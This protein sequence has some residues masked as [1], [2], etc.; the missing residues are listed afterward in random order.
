MHFRWP[1][2]APETKPGR[3][4]PAANTAFSKRCSRRPPAPSS[5]RQH[6]DI[7]TPTQVRAHPGR[8]TDCNTPYLNYSWLMSTAWLCAFTP[9]S[10]ISFRSAGEAR[11]AERSSAQAKLL[12]L[13]FSLGE[14]DFIKWTS[15]HTI[16]AT[17]NP[18]RFSTRK[19]SRCWQGNT[20]GC[21]RLKPELEVEN[22]FLSPLHIFF[23]LFSWSRA[24]VCRGGKKRSV[25]IFFAGLISLYGILPFIQLF[26]RSY[27]Y[28]WQAK[29]YKLCPKL[30]F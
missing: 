8:P 18:V 3:K 22:Y 24:A 6:P 14:Y 4:E 15:L 20:E 1:T 7:C 29:I 11:G 12:M 17:G 27:S 28:V 21:T 25:G 26:H 30:H 13:F 5:G 19:T 10:G 2:P 9:Q 23:P 16:T